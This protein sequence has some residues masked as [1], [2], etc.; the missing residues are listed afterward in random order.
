MS[1]IHIL[2]LFLSVPI[3]ASGQPKP[4]YTFKNYFYDFE[5]TSDSLQFLAIDGSEL[6]YWDINTFD[7]VKKFNQY[8]VV[9]FDL[10][11]NSNLLA[12]AI[13]SE[14]SYLLSFQTNE[15]I[16]EYNS[17]PVKR[18]DR[19]NFVNVGA[20]RVDISEDD[21]YIAFIDV[22]NNITLWSVETGDLLHSFGEVS[23]IMDV[24]ISSKYNSLITGHY[25]WDLNTYELK[26][27]LKYRDEIDD[28][29]LFSRSMD[30]SSNRYL[31]LAQFLRTQFV[32]NK[33][34]SI[35]HFITKW[36][37]DTNKLIALYEN[38]P[39]FIS[40]IA[41]SP[42]D[43]YLLAAIENI[44]VWL[45]NTESG[46]VINKFS[47]LYSPIEFSPNGKYALTGGPDG[48][49]SL[50]LVEDLLGQSNVENYELY[51]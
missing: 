51:Q 17:F 45:Y 15:L 39:N 2:L 20:F 36:D 49:A 5:F 33:G 4:I 38:I 23:N 46:E 35:E 32:L 29:L 25:I 12:V 22:L 19:G 43:K 31:Y 13:A 34:I 24:N 10:S 30:L 28:N 16:H 3:I 8:V 7:M 40:D 41:V 21:K 27:I 47:D 11:K 48:G 9:D 42:N 6:E 37:L 1:R 26:Q 50:W 44:G 18:D 14:K